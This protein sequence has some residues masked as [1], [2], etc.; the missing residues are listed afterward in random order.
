MK[1]ILVLLTVV[2]ALFLIY[3]SSRGSL[4]SAHVINLD[5]SVERLVAFRKNAE[6]VGLS[7]TRWPGIN[8]KALEASDMPR[9]GV[10]HHIYEK[11][12]TKKRLGVIGCYLSHSTL[13]AHLGTIQCG[14]NDYHLIFEDDAR[15]PADFMIQLPKIVAKLPADWDILQLYNNR[16][17]TLPWHGNIHTLAPGEGNYGTVAYVVRHDALSKI[18]AHVAV[19]RR[20]IDNQLLEKSHDWKWFCMVPDMVHTDDGGKTTLND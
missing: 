11:H 4:A 5:R 18:N 7:V 13:L 16:P 19:M 3:R 2:L 15:L 12:A 6:E 17:N 9:Y 20:P 14:Q 10:P 8:G 1:Y